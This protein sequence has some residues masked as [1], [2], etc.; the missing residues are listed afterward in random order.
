M[1]IIKKNDLEILSMEV[2]E[3]KIAIMFKEIISNKIVN[4]LHD[5]LIIKK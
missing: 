4:E 1:K 3:S 2:N 5:K